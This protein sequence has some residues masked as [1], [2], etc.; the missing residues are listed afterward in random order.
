MTIVGSKKM[1]V[2]D[3]VS[4]TAKIQIFDKGIDKKVKSGDLGQYS[5]FGDF[6]LLVRAGDVTIPKIN[7]VEPLKT[8]CSHFIECVV[9]NK[10]PLTDGYNGLKVTEI[11]EKAEISLK[12]NG[13]VIK[14]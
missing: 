11:L 7:F 12:D 9:Q 5:S 2:Y 4:N 8:E 10:R 6:Q 1:V 3:D 14:I 13:R